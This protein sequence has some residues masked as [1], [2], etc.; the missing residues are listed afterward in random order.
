MKRSQEY[1]IKKA[2]FLDKGKNEIIQKASLLRGSDELQEKLK[3]HSYLKEQLGE[4]LN[5]KD[6]ILSV[7]GAH[8]WKNILEKE[9]TVRLIKMEKDISELT[10]LIKTEIKK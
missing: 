5:L 8:N 2:E 3:N 1:I 4:D 9:V 7:E 6:I 10:E